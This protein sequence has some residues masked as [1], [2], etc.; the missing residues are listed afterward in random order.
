MSRKGF[1][2]GIRSVDGAADVV[3][4][5]GVVAFVVVGVECGEGGEYGGFVGRGFGGGEFGGF[6]LAEVET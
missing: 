3:H 1:G 4:V 2:V 5:V 6:F